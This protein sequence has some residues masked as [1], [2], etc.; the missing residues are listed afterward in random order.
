MTR[1]RST[2]RVAACTRNPR[3]GW[4]PGF[5]LPLNLRNKKS[6]NNFFSIV[7]V[8]CPG[9][10]N[11]MNIRL[12]YFA[13]SM[14]TVQRSGSYSSRSS[15]WFQHYRYASR[16]PSQSATVQ[17]SFLVLIQRPD[18]YCPCLWTQCSHYDIGF[19]S[20][21]VIKSWLFLEVIRTLS[22]WCSAP[23]PDDSGL[24]SRSQSPHRCM[25]PTKGVGRESCRFGSIG[26]MRGMRCRTVRA[27]YLRHSWLGEACEKTAGNGVTASWVFQKFLAML[28]GL[29]LHFFRTMLGWISFD[30]LV[31]I[32][33]VPVLLA[34]LQLALSGRNSSRHG[35]FGVLLVWSGSNLRCAGAVGSR[36]V[37]VSG[38][39]LGAC[40]NSWRVGVGA[41]G[42]AA[43][44]GCWQRGAV[45]GTLLFVVTSGGDVGSGSRV[46]SVDRYRN[47][48]AQVKVEGTGGESVVVWACGVVNQWRWRGYRH[49][50]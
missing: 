44:V 3:A 48:V 4:Q 2:A 42:S 9:L 38:T 28:S 50:P 26:G 36:K 30:T 1:M 34:G 40:G 24:S 14:D 32:F 19:L 46:Y 8:Q 11:F 35:Y 45:P 37:I 18:C 12:K 25:R 23:D 10:L 43:S 17:N 49:T 6:K 5:A 20:Q 47:G 15:L 7:T 41:H 33:V 29:D 21:P 13:L 22:L 27:P 39:G 31:N 16:F